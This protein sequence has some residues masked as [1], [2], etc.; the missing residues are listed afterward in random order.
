[1]DLTATTLCKENNLPLIVFNMDC[2]GNLIRVI[3]GEYLGSYVHKS[4]KFV[5]LSQIKIFKRHG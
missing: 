2:P 1:M 4:K 5:Y 3:S